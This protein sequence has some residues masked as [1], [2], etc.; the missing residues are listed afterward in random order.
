MVDPLMTVVRN[1]HRWPLGAPTTRLI[2]QTQLPHKEEPGSHHIQTRR[3]TSSPMFRKTTLAMLH[4]RQGAPFH[5]RH[6]RRLARLLPQ[7][8]LPRA[9]ESCLIK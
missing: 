6:L 2:P 5:L 8:I 1:R 9:A 3:V 7:G 4:P